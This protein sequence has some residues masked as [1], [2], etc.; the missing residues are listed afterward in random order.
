MEKF[1]VVLKSEYFEVEILSV[2]HSSRSIDKKIIFHSASLFRPFSDPPFCLYPLMK[3]YELAVRR[4]KARPSIWALERPEICIFRKIRRDWKL[5]SKITSSDHV[6][7]LSHS[8]VVLGRFSS[9][10]NFARNAYFAIVYGWKLKVS[11][12]TFDPLLQIFDLRK[13]G[14]GL[15]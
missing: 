12:W 6:L 15:R 7:T 4:F 11:I 1:I 5:S 8:S 10:Y 13:S 3:K 14:Y 9:L 2:F